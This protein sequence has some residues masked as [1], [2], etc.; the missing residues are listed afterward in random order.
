MDSPIEPG[1]RS[2][3]PVSPVA[4]GASAKRPARAGQQTDAEVAFYREFGHL[5]TRYTE[6]GNAKKEAWQTVGKGF[7]ARSPDVPTRTQMERHVFQ[8]E[9]IKQ[10]YRPVGSK[11]KQNSPKHSLQPTA[12]NGTLGNFLLNMEME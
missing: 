3:P 10:Q 9:T 8:N 1:E 11:T 12:A 7:P 5:T 4:L 2:I 6:G